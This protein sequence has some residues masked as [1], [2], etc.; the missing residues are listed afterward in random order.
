ME[1]SAEWAWSDAW[2]LAAIMVLGRDEGSSLTE[3]VAAAH[4]INHSILLENEIE[5]AVR[6]LLGVG[7]FWTSHRRFFLTDAGRTMAAKRRG[8][9]LG[10]VDHLLTTLRRLP[11]REQEWHL[12]LGELREAVDAWRQGAEALATGGRRRR[13]ASE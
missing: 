10:Q 7:L 8:G 3:V 9:M 4:A 11:V 12:E 5:P 13:P 6:R 2:V 1:G